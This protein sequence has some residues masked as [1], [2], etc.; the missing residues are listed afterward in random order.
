MF[1]F[2]S[3]DERLLTRQTKAY[4]TPNSS[5]QLRRIRLGCLIADLASLSNKGAEGAS[6]FEGPRQKDR[7]MSWAAGVVVED[8]DKHR[9][10]EVV[11]LR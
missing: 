1:P 2:V 11:G 7:K 3:L 10:S 6:L 5:Y 4:P 9:D 8:H